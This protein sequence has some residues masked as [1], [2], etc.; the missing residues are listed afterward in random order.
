MPN[1]DGEVTEGEG[2]GRTRRGLIMMTNGGISSDVE[3]RE[4]RTGLVGSKKNSAVSKDC[5]GWRVE[6]LGVTAEGRMPEREMTE[7]VA[8][9]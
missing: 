2:G 9:T 8:V 6:K 4:Q 3:G 7:N 1:K 5:W